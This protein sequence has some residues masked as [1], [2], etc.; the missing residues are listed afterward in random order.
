MH[1]PLAIGR[2]VVEHHIVEHIVAGSVARCHS[3]LLAHTVGD[4][5][6]GE[7][8]ACALGIDGRALAL[9]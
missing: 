9:V 3:A 6:V 7:F 8:E 5:G 2:V 4:G 1:T